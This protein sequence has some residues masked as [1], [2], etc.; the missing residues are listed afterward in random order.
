MMGGCAG[1]VDRGPPI[2]RTEVD[3]PIDLVAPSRRP[4]DVEALLDLESKRMK[5][6][7]LVGVVDDTALEPHLFQFHPA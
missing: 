4:R 2:V 1:A 3:W 6:V 7:K 5:D